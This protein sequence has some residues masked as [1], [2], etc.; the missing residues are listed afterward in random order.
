MPALRSFTVYTG[1]VDGN[2]HDAT[3]HRIQC[4]A[5]G[6]VRCMER[7]HKG[8]ENEIRMKCSFHDSLTR[9]A[10]FTPGTH[11]QVHMCGI[12]QR[13]CST[14]TKVRHI[15]ARRSEGADNLGSTLVRRLVT[16][17]H[18]QRDLANIRH[19]G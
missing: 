4:G 9:A 13:R 2:G 15:P 8:V 19:A 3:V 16:A 7:Q 1:W 14:L 17:D 11:W 5:R 10:L 6:E 12:T 18:V